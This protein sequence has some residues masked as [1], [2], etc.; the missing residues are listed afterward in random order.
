MSTEPIASLIASAR[1]GS[2]PVSS[3]AMIWSLM[4][5]ILSRASRQNGSELTCTCT[6]SSAILGLRAKPRTSLR[7]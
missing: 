1:S 3:F 7:V 4:A 6:I 2:T 5:P